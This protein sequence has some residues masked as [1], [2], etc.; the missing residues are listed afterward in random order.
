M[1]APATAGPWRLEIVDIPGMQG[2]WRIMGSSP[3]DKTLPHGGNWVGTVAR[4]NGDRGLAN[5]RIIAAGP[6]MLAALQACAIQL[7]M[8][9]LGGSA[10]DKARAAIAKATKGGL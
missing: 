3:H 5:A 7:D 6:E 9:T 8:E 4:S 2:Q 10:L 1:S